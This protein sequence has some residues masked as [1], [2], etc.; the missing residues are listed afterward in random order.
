MQKRMGDASSS[1]H[2]DLVDYTCRAALDIIAAAGSFSPTSTYTSVIVSIYPSG[3]GYETDAIEHGDDNE[4]ARAFNVVV[5]P[6]SG[7]SIWRLI[8]SSL[9]IV[10]TLVRTFAFA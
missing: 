5:G 7:L 1:T 8:L 4:L 9:P 2:L 3:F 10:E 6:S